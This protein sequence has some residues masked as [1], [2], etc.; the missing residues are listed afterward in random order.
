[1]QCGVSVSSA[2]REGYLHLAALHSFVCE[3]GGA[4]PALL[5]LVSQQKV[6][7]ASK[8]PVSCPHKA[9]LVSWTTW[10]DHPTTTELWSGMY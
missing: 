2:I 1:M 7:G 10:Q 3:M 4:T 9:V 6:N 8:E 5:G